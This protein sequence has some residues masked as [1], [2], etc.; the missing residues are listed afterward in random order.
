MKVEIEPRIYP[1]RGGE[2]IVGNV[3]QGKPN[4]R[5]FRLVVGVVSRENNR[6]WNNVV[7]LSIDA[8]GN[9]VG[10]SCQPYAYVQE[11]QDLIGR[12]LE[13]PSLKIEWLREFDR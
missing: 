6:P 1:H 4:Q 5:Y 13:M 3:Y 12:V 11:H 10:A 8:F 2:V 7:C 9:V